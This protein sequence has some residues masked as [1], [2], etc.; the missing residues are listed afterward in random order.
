[1]DRV[2][3][4]GVLGAASDLLLHAFWVRA[5]L[6]EEHIQAHSRI[7][8]DLKKAHQSVQVALKKWRAVAEKW[9]YGRPEPGA[10]LTQV[11]RVEKIRLLNGILFYLSAV[12]DNLKSGNEDRTNLEGRYQ[13]VL[14]LYRDRIDQLIE[15][16]HSHQGY[17]APRKMSGHL[18]AVERDLDRLLARL[19]EADSTSGTILHAYEVTLPALEKADKEERSHGGPKEEQWRAWFFAWLA[20]RIVREFVD[21]LEDCESSTVHNFMTKKIYDFLFSHA[22]AFRIKHL[23]RDRFS[24]RRLKWEQGSLPKLMKLEHWK[25][26]ERTLKRMRESK[27]F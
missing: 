26:V 22:D 3:E 4:R 21:E 20:E 24:E 23:K 5:R 2:N 16:G 7:V 12:L 10:T 19:D 8:N 9:Q 18:P 25:L 13:E 27:R 17:Q 15:L 14:G 1:M 11:E 6:W